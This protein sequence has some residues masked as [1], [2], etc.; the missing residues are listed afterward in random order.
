MTIVSAADYFEPQLDQRIRYGMRCA[1][2]RSSRFV[3]MACGVGA[4]TD[5]LS[6]RAQ[7]GH[8]PARVVRTMFRDAKREGVSSEFG[9]LLDLQRKLLRR[10]ARHDRTS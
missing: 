4:P 10:P 5:R 3:T 8:V 2:P 9:P 7:H 6:K 1:E